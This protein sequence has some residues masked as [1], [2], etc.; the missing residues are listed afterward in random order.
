M[1]RIFYGWWV[2]A[3]AALGLFFGAA[4]IIVYSFGVFIAPL[5]HEF[6]A[7]RAAI[8]FAFTLFGLAGAPGALAVGRLIDRF[9]ARR[10][11][12]TSMVVFAV[13]LLSNGFFSGKIWHLYVLYFILGL[14]GIGSSP[15]AFSDVISHWFD[16]FRGLALGLMMF[17]MG[18]AA[19]IMP[20]LLEHMIAAFGWRNAYRFY[21]VAVLLI[22]VPLLVFFLKERPESM[23]LLPDGDTTARAIV[24]TSRKDQGLP[25]S[26]ARRDRAF[27]Y[28]IFA[29]FLLMVGLQGCVVHL[30]SLLHDRGSTAQIG[31]LAA[32]C[33]GAALFVGRVCTGYFLDRLFA[34]YVAAFLFGQAAL[35]MLLLAIHG[36]NWLPFVS[37]VSVGLGIGAEADVMAYMASRYFGLRCF[38]EIYSYLWFGFVISV[39]IGPYLMGL[40]FDKTGS[41]RVPLLAFVLAASAATMLIARLGPYRFGPQRSASASL[42]AQPEAM[43]P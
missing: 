40:G 35:G 8:S 34:P 19:V 42:E 25:W 16:R 17:G 1:P 10:I 30:P 27:W 13:M 5:T 3:V 29:F 43:N 22:G 14:A 2:V 4:P 21:A 9:G 20:T 33:I 11:A 6:H 7:S 26:A 39:A 41:Y 28:M 23:G 12:I 37:A 15:L 31:A 38:A 36:P 24:R 18:I 32:S